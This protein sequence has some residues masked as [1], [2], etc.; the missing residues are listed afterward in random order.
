M[1]FC[2]DTCT[3]TD[4]LLQLAELMHPPQPKQYVFSRHDWE[5][6]KDKIIDA[7]KGKP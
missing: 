2:I 4:S 6:H 7:L 5:Q 3:D 1:D